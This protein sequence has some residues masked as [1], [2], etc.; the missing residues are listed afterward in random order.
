[1]YY[2]QLTDVKYNKN[3]VYSFKDTYILGEKKL[4]KI[5]LFVCKENRYMK[6]IS[7]AHVHHTSHTHTHNRVLL[8]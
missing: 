3:I 5:T 8:N 4:I 6:P 7:D 1:M 2:N